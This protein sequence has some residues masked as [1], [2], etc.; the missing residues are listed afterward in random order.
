MKSKII[1]MKTYV[2]WDGS[3]PTYGDKSKRG[4]FLLPGFAYVDCYAPIPADQ[5][6]RRYVC[7]KCGKGYLNPESLKRHCRHE[8]GKK[9]GFGCP[10]CSHRTKQKGNMVTHIRLRHPGLE[11]VVM[12]LAENE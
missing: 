1:G 9:P 6:E 2:H 12:E 3:L 4:N 11:P 5:R 8:C 7:E 10:Y